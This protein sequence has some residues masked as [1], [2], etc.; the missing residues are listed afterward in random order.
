[1]PSPEPAPALVVSVNAAASHAWPGG[2][3][4]EG[5]ARIGHALAGL[6][7][8]LGLGGAGPVSEDSLLSA[9]PTSP[10]GLVRVL[11]GPHPPPPA[12]LLAVIHPPAYLAALGAI[13]THTKVADEDDEAEFTYAGPATAGEAARAVGAVVAVVDAVCGWGGGGD[14]GGGRTATATTTSRPAGFALVRPPGHHAGPG[15]GPDLAASAL[16]LG[17]GAPAGTRGRAPSGFCFL[18]NVACAAAHARAAWGLPRPLIIDLDVH[19]GDGTQAALRGWGRGGALVADFHQAGVWPHDTGAVG[20]TG[21]PEGPA[22]I[23]VPLPPGSG[24]AGARA[25][26]DRVVAPAAAAFRPSIVFVSLGLDA[27]AADPLGGLCWRS[28]TYG[29]LVDGAAGLADAYAGGRLVVVLEGGYSA[30]GLVG[31]TA[32][33]ARALVGR[34]RRRRD[35]DATAR[36]AADDAL[37]D[38]GTDVDEEAERATDADVAAALDEVCARHG[39]KK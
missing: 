3:S 34:V 20:D 1:M 28:R 30:A 12:G 14:E 13:G 36:T 9:A 6:A 37:D 38:C 25:A 29:A 8:G 22:V 24:D 27:H 23:N 31:G 39:L 2:G 15:S 5:P 18:S 26:F 19:V 32:A 10:P 33:A 16:G 17:G 7:R 11:P 35:G 4:P 21:P